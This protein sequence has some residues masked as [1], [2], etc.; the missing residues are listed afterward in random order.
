M[1]LFK[2]R[3]PGPLGQ[4]SLLSGAYVSQ[5]NGRQVEGR[6][7]Q[8]VLQPFLWNEWGREC[9]WGRILIINYCYRSK[10]KI[11]MNN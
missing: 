7:A 10:M 5:R 9:E 3:K 1:L 8:N 4:D 11:K 6:Q 2:F